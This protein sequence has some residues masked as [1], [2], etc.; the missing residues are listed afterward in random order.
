MSTEYNEGLE[1]IESEI[2]DLES[3]PASYDVI[4]YPAPISLTPR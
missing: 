1:E 4:T 3:S 2:S